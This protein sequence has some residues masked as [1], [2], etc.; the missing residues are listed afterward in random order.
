MFADCID[1]QA[2][3]ELA[4]G[5]AP[6]GFFEKHGQHISMCNRCASILKTYLLDFSDEVTPEEDAILSGL[7]NSRPEGQSALLEMLLQHMKESQGG[8]AEH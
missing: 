3:Q 6:A 5:I 1:E 7:E 2:L 4:A 8:Q